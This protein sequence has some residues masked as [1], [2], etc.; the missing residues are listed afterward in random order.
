LDGLAR[1]TGTALAGL[2]EVAA[3]VE[4]VVPRGPL[5][6]FSGF[7]GVAFLATTGDFD[8]LRFV[9]LEAVAIIFS[10]K[11]KIY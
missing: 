2:T 9:F 11:Q 7:A 5:A 1:L 10:N 3:A 8:S 4:L 6:L